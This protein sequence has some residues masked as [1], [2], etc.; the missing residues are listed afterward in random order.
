M[1]NEN[2]KKK[3]TGGE[4]REKNRSYNNTFIMMTYLH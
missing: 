3:G 1:Q 2:E 4:E